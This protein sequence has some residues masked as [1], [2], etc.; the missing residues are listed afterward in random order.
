MYVA[1]R[2]FCVC[3]IETDGIH[4]VGGDCELCQKSGN[5]GTFY[6]AVFVK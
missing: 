5:E 2:F 6:Y 3:Y 1:G 4:V